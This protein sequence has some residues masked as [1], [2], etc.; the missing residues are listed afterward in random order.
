MKENQDS[1]GPDESREPESSVARRKDPR[2]EAVSQQEVGGASLQ[3]KLRRGRSS[4]RQ[5][6]TQPGVP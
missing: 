4:H 6:Q 5:M 1:L 3:V 2:K